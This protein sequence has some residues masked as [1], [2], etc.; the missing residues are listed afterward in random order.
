ME[1]LRLN[2]NSRSR[3]V[4]SRQGCESRNMA[5]Q[6]EEC[7]PSVPVQ[8]YNKCRNGNQQLHFVCP[9]KY[10][11]MIQ[12]HPAG[13]WC[14][15][16]GKVCADFHVSKETSVGCG[17]LCVLY[18]Y[19]MDLEPWGVTPNPALS[20]NPPALCQGSTSNRSQTESVAKRWC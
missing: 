20:S 6:P 16:C 11:D 19:F 4:S 17:I 15:M 1:Y 12:K 9:K 7:R 5:C 3:L 2:L 13:S 10:K 18:A 14:L 8:Q